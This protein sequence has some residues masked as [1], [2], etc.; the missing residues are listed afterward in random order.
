MAGSR[1][2]SDS[3]KR[4]WVPLFFGGL[5]SLSAFLLAQAVLVPQ[6]QPGKMVF[7]AAP[8]LFF[9]GLLLLLLLRDP[10]Q[11]ALLCFPFMYLKADVRLFWIYL[12]LLFA[13]LALSWPRLNLLRSG[14]SL[15]EQLWLVVILAF[16]AMGCLNSSQPLEQLP[17]Y[18]GSYVFPVAMYVLILC[19]PGEAGF[20]DRL[21][22]R[23]LYAYAIVGMLSMCYKLLHPD[24]VRVA[25]F[26]QMSVTMTG[27]TSAA[28]VP[29]ALYYVNREKNTVLYGTLFA[30]LMAA[31]VLTNTRFA[32][33]MTVLALAG[34]VGLLRKVLLPMALVGS[35]ILVVGVQV[36]FSRFDT[37]SAQTFDISLAARF[38]AWSTCPAIL[39]QFPLTGIGINEFREVYL[40]FARI[41]LIELIHA[42]NVV[43][44]KAMEIGIPG[45]FVY[46]A[47]VTRR[48]LLS[49]RPLDLLRV[50]GDLLGAS[51]AFSLALYLLAGLIESIFLDI[52]WTTWFWVLMA[53]MDRHRRERLDTT[54]VESP[55]GVR[56]PN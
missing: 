20:V 27:Y 31:M 22:R 1:R 51:L 47:F 18:I 23:F 12:P 13:L 49:Y 24:A 14:L 28:L 33:G 19:Y 29:I 54:A 37:F 7:L 21:L 52:K 53:L 44:N 42:H 36:L 26:I 56:E 38:I 50:R 2:I 48:V 8:A 9:C 34:C 4:R 30:L 43:L 46:L 39:S 41:P 11:V 25:G 17:A 5:A 32:V 40:Q 3:V 10:F 35:A 45:M 16:G 55:P 6:T 15:G